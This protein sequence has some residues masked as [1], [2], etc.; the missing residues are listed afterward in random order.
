MATDNNALE[1][2]FER[3][4]AY[5]KEADKMVIN[6]MVNIYRELRRTNE[7]ND[8]KSKEITKEEVK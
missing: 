2:K 4:V 5:R 6:L 1:T 7:I 8:K 3:Y